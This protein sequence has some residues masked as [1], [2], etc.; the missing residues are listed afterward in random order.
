MGVR[1]HKQAVRDAVTK[2]AELSRNQRALSQARNSKVG[3]PTPRSLM[4]SLQTQYPTRLHM[5]LIVAA[6][7]CVAILTTRW[8]LAVG[9]EVIGL[10]YAVALVMSY[11]TF[12]VGVWVWLHLSKYGRHLR[13]DWGRRDSH[14]DLSLDG[15][16]NIDFGSGGGSPSGDAPFHGAGGAFDGG[17][18]SASWDVP[19]TQLSIDL[20]GSDALSSVGDIGDVGGD[21]GG[22]LI[23]IALLL[24]AVALFAVFGAAAYVIY[25]APAILAE[26]V[27]EVLLASPLA[28]GVRAL[29]SANWPSVLLRKTWRPFAV[30]AGAAM[31]F[32]VYCHI[33]RPGARTAAEVF[34]SSAK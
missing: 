9:V 20:P 16:P 28:R 8:M 21:E 26:V 1:S 30:I 31:L 25:Q 2:S 29:D 33:E 13:A 5:F 18:A 22:C 11:G 6:C 10:R 34:Q 17:G 7:I 12:F 23:V 15:L 32:A 27:F 4:S 3:P 19:D 24:L 14:G